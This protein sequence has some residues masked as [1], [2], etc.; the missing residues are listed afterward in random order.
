MLDSI[1]NR[2]VVHFPIDDVAKLQLLEQEFRAVSR[3]GAWRG[4]V[5][6]IDGVHFGIT[7]PTDR[8]V[9]NSG[10]YYVGRKNEYAILC[11][12]GCDYARRIMYYD[13]HLASA[14]H[15]HARF[16]CV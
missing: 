12:A 15:N 14:H 8:D 6:C 5:M 11:M 2:L 13:R 10:R 7:Y 3:G 4:Q 16:S 9:R 1:N